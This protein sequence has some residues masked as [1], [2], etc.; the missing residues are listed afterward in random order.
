MPEPRHGLPERREDRDQIAAEPSAVARDE[1]RHRNAV[2]GGDAGFA[3]KPERAHGFEYRFVG[4]RD[5]NGGERDAARRR[6]RPR[7]LFGDI[8]VEPH[9]LGEHKLAAAAPERYV[10]LDGSD[11]PETVVS[12]AL[13]AL[14]RLQ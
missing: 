14:K 3:G 6:C 5:Q 13:T 8:A 10:V 1:A 11:A 4:R 9:V 7:E 12:R 2:P